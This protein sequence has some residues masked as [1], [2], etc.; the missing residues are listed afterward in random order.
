[1]Q[2]L[3][4][5]AGLRYLVVPSAAAG[6]L[7]VLLLFIASRLGSLISLLAFGLLSAAVA[8]GLAAEIVLWVARGVRRLELDEEELLLY[9]GRSLEKRRVD[10]Q[11]VVSLRVRSRLGRKTATLVLTS[12]ESVRLAGDAFSEE[13]FARF[14]A[15]LAEWA[16]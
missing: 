4:I 3:S 10:V 9:R 8:A 13:E 5:D 14:L 15:A 12:G 2:R 6:L 16:P 7:L 1:M 11:S